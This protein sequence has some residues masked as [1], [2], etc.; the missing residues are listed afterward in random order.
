MPGRKPLK[1]LQ[2]PFRLI[3]IHLAFYGEHERSAELIQSGGVINWLALVAINAAAGTHAGAGFSSHAAMCFRAQVIDINIVYDAAN[4]GLQ[5][6][7]FIIAVEAIGYSDHTLPA[8][9]ELADNALCFYII[10]GK[11]G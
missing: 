7:T 11:S 8:K 6:I 3:W 4:A 1:D 9:L 2:Y 10:A 5:L